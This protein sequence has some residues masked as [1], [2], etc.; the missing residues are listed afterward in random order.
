MW[1]VS[2]DGAQTWTW[3][4]RHKLSAVLRSNKHWNQYEY[5]RCFYNPVKSNVFIGEVFIS[6]Y[7]RNQKQAESTNLIIYLILDKIKI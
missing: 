1:W 6:A 7:K 5:T 4:Q 3:F 2:W